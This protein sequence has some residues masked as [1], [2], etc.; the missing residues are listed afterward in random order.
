MRTGIS[1]LQWQTDIFVAN[2]QFQGKAS[3]IHEILQR[4]MGDTCAELKN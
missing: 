2:L 4:R 1:V 3:E